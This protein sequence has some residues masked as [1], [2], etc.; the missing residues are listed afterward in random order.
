[1]N[2][3]LILTQVGATV[4]KTT[5]LADGLTL[6]DYFAAKAMQ[7]LLGSKWY[8]ER[9]DK[10]TITGVATD[11]ATDSYEAADAMLAQRLLH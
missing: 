1:M 2:N 6:R 3:P 10:E 5:A 7:T 11:L 9:S 8:D 4:P